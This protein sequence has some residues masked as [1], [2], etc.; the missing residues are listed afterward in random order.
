MRYEWRWVGFI[1]LLMLAIAFLPFIFVSLM[2]DY[3]GQF[4]GA[5]HKYQD[6]AAY[7]SRMEQGARG[8]WLVHLQH[9]PEPHLSAL[10]NPLYILLGQISRFTLNSEVVIFHVARLS[11]SIF[12]YLSIYQLA[13]N[14]WVKVRTRR[15]FFVIASLASGLGWLWALGTGISQSPDLQ[16]AQA[17]PYYASLVNVHFPLTI[18]CLALLTSLA[19]AILR[20]A[21]LERP[22]A[23][24]V[25]ITAMLASLALSFLYPETLLPFASA[26]AVVTLANSVLQRR[27]PEVELAWMLWLFAPV[28]P[29]LTYF[30]LTYLSNPAIA[31]WVRQYSSQAF[32]PI[33]MMIGFAVPLL[34][35]IPALWRAVRRFEAD[36]DRFMLLWLLAMLGAYYLL[37]PAR[38][39]FLTAL[40]LPLAYFA[41]RGI[42][43]FWLRLSGRKMHRIAYVL[44]VFSLMLSPLFV[45]FLPL[46]S[47]EV[48]AL[49]PAEYRLALEWLEQRVTDENVILASPSVSA[50]IPLWTGARTVY[51]HERES[52]DVQNKR[53]QVQTWYSAED[54]ASCQSLRQLQTSP[55]GYYYVDYMLLGERERQLGDGQC[56]QALELLASFN[57]LNL[58][59]CNIECKLNALNQP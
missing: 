16:V 45:T 15:L 35:G 54:S 34:L 22:S 43:D 20:P 48:Q 40:S 50:W 56:L 33:S 37:A 59:W 11:A 49:P 31:E 18:A 57:T 44:G 53:Q 41:T 7:L 27:R 42:E 6:A 36:G 51:G 21:G 28:V 25:G 52:L 39:A 8:E 13:A 12:M 24:Q 26:F 5:I 55:F 1:S 23:N 47:A 4:M 29:L 19:I 3:Q 17:S 2:P 30:I 58:Y 38:V 32:T 10:I 9:T 14:I 46:S